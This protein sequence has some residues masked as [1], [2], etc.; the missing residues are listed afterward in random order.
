LLQE[1][2]AFE[3]TTKLNE[4]NID[5]KYRD[6]THAVTQSKRR[7]Q[8]SFTLVIFNLFAHMVAS[9]YLS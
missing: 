3:T 7:K 9:L 8:K 6:K 5:F 4:N 2:P 1:Q